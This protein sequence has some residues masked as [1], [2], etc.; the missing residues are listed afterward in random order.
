M[1]LSQNANED[2]LPTRCKRSIIQA[3]WPCDSTPP[4][5]VPETERWNGYFEYYTTECRKAVETS[6]G[7]NVTVRRHEDVVTI[8]RQFE[9]ES[10]KERIKHSLTLLDTRQR[11]E[12]TKNRMAEG[13]VRLVMRLFAMVDVGPPSDNWAWGPPCLSWDNE[14]L[15]VKAVLANH[16]VTSSKDPENLVFEED[17]TAF[18]LQ[19]LA[20]LHIQWTNS[21][22]NHL[23]LIDNDRK[24]CVFYQATFLQRQNR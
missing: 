5:V 18:N 2:P 24:L 8:A 22:A 13:S 3:L 17:F 10:T 14:D 11:N 19:R 23:R 6:R 15:D 1:P 7:E 16:F 12:T 20:G 21:L 4:V 9:T